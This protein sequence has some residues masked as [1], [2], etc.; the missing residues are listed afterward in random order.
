MASDQDQ[1]TEDAT[2][3]KQEEA[4]EKGQVPMS[5][6][7]VAAVLLAGWMMAALFQGGGVAGSVGS[8]LAGSISN[9]GVLGPQEL[10]QIQ[11]A[12]LMADLGRMIGQALMVVMLPLLLLGMLV[13]YGQIGF[14][15]TPQALSFDFSRLDPIKG[16]GRLL[17]MR[18]VVRTVM[19]LTKI[20]LIGGT[21]ITIGWLQIDK[22]TQLAGS[23]LGP[24][25][26]GIGH[27][28]GRAV[29]GAIGVVI[30]LAVIDLVYQRFQHGRDL[31]MSKQEIRD[32]MKS[33]EGDPHVKGRIRR[34]QREMASRRMLADVPDAT[35]V[36]TNPTHYAVALRY[37]AEE[38]EG[39]SA[40]RVV[41]KGVDH[42]AQKI[43]A[44]ARDA[45]VLLFEDVPLARALHAQC[46]I[47][48]QVPLELY[49]AVAGVLAYVYRVQG[50]VAKKA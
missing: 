13:G 37:E 29:A 21:M 28:A 42:V 30:L 20:L 26:A 9:V 27:I 1:K 10:D 3:R 8:V 12:A 25:L 14:R 50:D 11:I 43:K 49:E 47:G 19:A 32:E 48:D 35:V 33:T 22:V 45:G 36:V 16:F 46:E 4:R 18:S 2:L 5:T 34:V 7:F 6:E 17:S 44:V 23:E 38:R 31:R 24:V 40:P 15:V 41:A 39:K